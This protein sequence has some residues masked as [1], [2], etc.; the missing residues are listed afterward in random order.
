MCS[1]LQW[2][3]GLLAH[4][5]TERVCT[6]VCVQFAVVGLLGGVEMFLDEE[7]ARHGGGGRAGG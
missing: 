3:R 5:F 7:G 6:C 2:N 1:E 4:R